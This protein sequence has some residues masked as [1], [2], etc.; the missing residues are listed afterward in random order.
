MFECLLYLLY[1]SKLKLEHSS[2][3]ADK[4]IPQQHVVSKSERVHTFAPRCPTDQGRS[5]NVT[6]RLFSAE[7]LRVGGRIYRAVGAQRPRQ[8]QIECVRLI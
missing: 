5:L 2:M 4:S 8:G 1:I 3:H 6:G 7:R